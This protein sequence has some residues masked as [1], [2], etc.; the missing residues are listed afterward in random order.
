MARQNPSIPLLP[1][2]FYLAMLLFVRF[3]LCFFLKN[4]LFLKKNIG[5]GGGQARYHPQELPHRPDTTAR[6]FP[7]SSGEGSRG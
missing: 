7:T 2:A 6:S 5:F 3:W 4:L 1:A